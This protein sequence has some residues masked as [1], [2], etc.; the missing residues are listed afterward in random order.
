MILR[1]VT[2]LVPL[3]G[4]AMALVAP[5]DTP[6]MATQRR[7]R[8][9]AAAQSNAWG[10][11]GDTRYLGRELARACEWARSATSTTFVTEPSI[12]VSDVDTMA[13]FLREDYDPVFRRLGAKDDATVAATAR[14][15][16]SL[17]PAAYDPKANVIHIVPEYAFAAAQAAGNDALRSE[18]VLQLL[19]VRM[20]TI[21]L[22]RQVYAE[23]KTALASAE[24]LDAIA[25]AGA[26]L[27]GHAQYV[28][29]RVGERRAADEGLAASAY[30]NLVALLTA[31]PATAGDDPT[32]RTLLAEIRTSVTQGEPFMQAIARTRTPG[33]AGVFRS[34][35]TDRSAL[36]DPKAW[37]EKQRDGGGASAKGPG[38]LQGKVQNEFSNVL[39]SEGT[40]DQASTEIGPDEARALVAP[41]AAAVTSMAIAAHQS[42]F[43]FS[44]RLA[45]NSATDTPTHEIYVIEFR[46]AGPAEAFVDL[47]RGAGRDRGAR[48]EDGAGRDG[49]LRGFHGVE[50]VGEAD[51]RITWRMQWTSEGPY[52]IGIR[53]DAD[54]DTLADALDLALESV[55]EVVGKSADT[56]SD[57]RKKK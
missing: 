30:D 35:P 4:I 43:R 15:A 31:V 1:P 6:E 50:E 9:A 28:A 47:L 12:A 36:F 24:T 17:V 53:T 54:G 48:L 44:G 55:A 32:T 29:K 2:L 13:A 49:G 41:L 39:M 34:P 46:S 33:V 37:I 10:K 11:W 5:M 7:G 56:R 38:G 26:V 40:W 3:L 18:G 20:A 14:I 52:A 23:W 27:Q 19:L 8:G 21:A 42:G 45:D 16:A 22:D 57:R 51:A 25:L